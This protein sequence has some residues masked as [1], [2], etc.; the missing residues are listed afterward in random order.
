M[1][2][3]KI[4]GMLVRAAMLCGALVT[5][6]VAAAAQVQL[7]T[8]Q[9][10][11]K[12]ARQVTAR[13]SEPMVAFGDPRLA[14]PFNVQCDGDPARLKGR[15]RWVDSRNWSYDFESDLPAGQRCRFTLKP[16]AK[17]AS[18]RAIDGKRDFA[19]HTG[20]PAIIRSRPSE[21][22]ET[23]DENQVFLL[24]LD[25]PFDTGSLSDAWCEAAGVNERIPLKVLSEK[26]T[27]EILQADHD[28]A[29]DLFAVYRKS[30]PPVPRALFKIEDKRWRDLPLAGVRCAQ[31]L[32]AEAEVKLVLG[33]RVKTRTG[34][35]RSTAQTLAFKVRAAFIVKL[36]C[37]RAN[38]D[39][40]CLPVTPITLDFNAPVP[41]DA[42]AGIR[43][44]SKD[45][46]S[47]EPK[48]EEHVKTVDRIQFEAPF[49]EKMALT[50]DL[51]RGFKD[52]A[53]REP[54]NK[55]AFPLVTGTDEYPPLAKF[56]GRFG[57][58]EL[59]ADPLLPVTVRNVEPVLQGRRTE[60]GAT[61]PGRAAR[62]DDETAILQRS[63][64]YMGNEHMR[65][66]G[67][68]SQ[69]YP[70]EGEI[71]AIAENEKAE[72]F[73]VPR[74]HGEKDT[75]VIG[76]PL[77]KPGYYIVELA[78]P[79]L[80]RAL[81]GEDKPY[82][83][84]TSVLVTNLA[85]HLKYGRESSLVWVTSL[86]QGKPV[87][88][89]K[90]TVRDCS[91]QIW[92]EGKSDASGIANLGDKLPQKEAVR[93]CGDHRRVLTVFAR[94]GD[95]LSFTFSDWDR[96]I[97]PWNFNLRSGE[98]E[99]R[100]VSIHTIFDRTL[101]RAGETVS[102]KHLARIPTGAGF[103]FPQ[104]NEIPSALH[105]EHV[106]SGQKFKL[107]ARFDAQGVA[108]NTW[109]IPSEAKLGSYQLS[110]QTKRGGM[111]GGGFRVEAFRVPLMRAVLAPPKEAL[112]KP[113][114]VKLDAAV[115]YLAGGPAPNL[116]VKVRYRVEERSIQFRD[117][118]DFQFGGKPLKEG[119]EQGSVADLWSTF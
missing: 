63:R 18:G 82:Y 4:S 27:R 40:A 32:P 6:G 50:V 28:N 38:K 101:F 7:F 24:A 20:G 109:V 65:R 53:G 35:E 25:A 74:A 36:T 113:A 105:I 70:N 16:D 90:V 44:K 110:W 88:N 8:P 64:S 71:R 119:I 112:V 95:D 41:R 106:G 66:A 39:A 59:N 5:I 103:R 68:A 2:K 61:I 67:K 79:R 46:K 33:P 47:F 94:A 22:D 100:P 85:V 89:A 118:G 72:R 45:G 58:L 37:Q 42:A 13:F 92:F 26:E 51:P 29:Y 34:I 3:N 115:T 17:D 55:S 93:H 14:D 77:K 15:G 99:R 19:F 104:D 114:A 1:I 10:E 87:A 43:M 78:S 52:D 54:Q 96:G 116:P 80:G 60:P 76:I 11:A 107:E 69:R 30:G 31:R 21:G 62:I 102:M 73:E 108:E 83:V 56:P 117:H 86:D 12:G 23:I 111:G 91:G 84:S 81:H 57:I 49:P 97:Q 75:E 9:G 98:H 48:L